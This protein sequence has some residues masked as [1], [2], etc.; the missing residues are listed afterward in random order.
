[1]VAHN[2]TLATLRAHIWKT[3]GDVVLYYK[4]NGR[5]PELEEE[6]AQKLAKHAAEEPSAKTGPVMPL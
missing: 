4:S 5:R 1:L 6:Y 2:T 3:G